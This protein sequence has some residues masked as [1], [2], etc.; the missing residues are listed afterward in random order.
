MVKAK[1]RKT[2]FQSTLTI[3]DLQ[4][5][6]NGKFVCQATNPFG[7]NMKDIEIAVLGE[8]RN[9]HRYHNHHHNHHDI[10]VI[11]FIITLP[12]ACF[13]QHSSNA[14]RRI[15]QLDIFLCYS[16]YIR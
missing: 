5:D 14:G 15:L 12:V 13:I 11:V 9:H 6:D 3:S 7:G 10:I 2:E 16:I 8:P 1:G 4:R